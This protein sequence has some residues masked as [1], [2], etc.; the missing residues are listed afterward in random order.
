MTQQVLSS[1][2]SE[3]IFQVLYRGETLNSCS[4]SHG[5]S[6]FY[7][8][9]LSSQNCT[10]ITRQRCRNMFDSCCKYNT[11]KRLGE[12]RPKTSL[13]RLARL[14]EVMVLGVTSPQNPCETLVFLSKARLARLFPPMLTHVHARMRTRVINNFAYRNGLKITSL[15]F[16]NLAR[17][18]SNARRQISVGSIRRTTLRTDAR[19]LP[20]RDT[21]RAS[22]SSRQW[23]NVVALLGGYR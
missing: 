20:S 4:E 9:N 8:C 11:A 12:F 23:A 6:A 7:V 16:A 3:V 17:W 19:S 15:N 21:S 14:G 13:A 18:F 2:V 22:H 1:E 10:S 5:I